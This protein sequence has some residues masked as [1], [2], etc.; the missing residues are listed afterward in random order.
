MFFMDYMENNPLTLS[1]PPSLGERG[2]VRGRSFS[3]FVGDVFVM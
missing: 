2:R 3:S 1:S